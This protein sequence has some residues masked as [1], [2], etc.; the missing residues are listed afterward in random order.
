[1]RALKKAVHIIFMAS[2]HFA[3]LSFYVSEMGHRFATAASGA[4]GDRKKEKK[5]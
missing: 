3:Y 5:L 4:K 2:V 1:M